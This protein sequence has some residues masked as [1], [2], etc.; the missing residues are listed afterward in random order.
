MI[1]KKLEREARKNGAKY[2]RMNALRREKGDGGT[3]DD[4]SD[5]SF[6]SDDSDSQQTPGKPHK[7]KK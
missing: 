7:S 4:D 2:K 1:S 5:Q 3:E 6:T